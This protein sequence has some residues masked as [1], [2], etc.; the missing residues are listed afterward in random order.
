M[1][2]IRADEL[3]H[4]CLYSSIAHAVYTLN[5]PFFAY[6]QSWDNYNY[7]FHFGSSRGTIT[8]D[9]KRNIV[10]GA[11]RKEDSSRIFL[12]PH[13]MSAGDLYRKASKEIIQLST[14]ETLMYLYDTIGDFTGPVATTGFWLEKDQLFLCDSEAVFLQHGGEYLKVLLNKQQGIKTYWEEQYGLSTKEIDLVDEVFRLY[15]A[16]GNKLVLDRS[17]KALT[18]QKGYEEMVKC[19]A[20]IGITVKVKTGLF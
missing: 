6:E 19:F 10:A 16:G 9:L 8:F 11:M 15:L 12:Y 13:E 2:N 1:G 14:S 3:F 7:N 5:N 4:N 18:K 20:E 17:Y